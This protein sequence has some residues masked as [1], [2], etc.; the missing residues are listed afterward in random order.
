MTDLRLTDFRLLATGM[1]LS[2]LGN[3]FQTI[4]LAVAVLI[5]GGSA[6]DLGLVMACSVLAM[7]ACTLF[8]GV[9]ADRVQPQR[10]MVA[11]D[12]VRVVTTAAIA[13][14]F[15]SGSYQL[16]LLCALAAVSAGAGAF[17]EPAMTA[18]RP[19]L[20]DVARRQH[21]NAT[22]SL[23]QTSCRVVGPALGG[24]VVAQFGASTGFAVN[25]AS[26]VASGAA[27]LLIRARTVRVPGEGML[28]ELGAGWR[29]IRQRDWLLSGVLAATVY[30][31]ANGILLVLVPVLAIERLGG[32]QAAGFIAAAEGLGGVIGAA[33]A[34]RWRPARLLYAGWLTLLLM[35]LW[36]LAFVWPGTLTAVLA[37]AVIG[38]AGLNF[39]GVAWDTAIQDHIPHHLL[40]RVASWDILTSLLAM[41]VG[42][43]LAGP[44]AAALGT[45]RILTLSAL[46]LFGSAL[47]P[48]AYA[49]TRSLTRFGPQD[50]NR[51]GAPSSEPISAAQSSGR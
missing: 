27:A 45:D 1:S 10:V 32:A 47:I 50:S 33:I 13:V 36:A 29:E 22:L 6:G 18:L 21:A 41:P 8:G 43:A 16:P 17:F 48:L 25:A 3:G 14:M 44:L 35:P 11:S 12:A 49:G 15:A 30:H 24:L 23:L 51:T 28:R 39:Y 4:A 5:S 34:L 46:V 38:Y 26:F 42:N 40:A 9:W 37:G 7:L 31:V 2:W 20:V 19:M